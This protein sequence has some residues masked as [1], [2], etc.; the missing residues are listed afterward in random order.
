MQKKSQ[1]PLINM[2]NNHEDDDDAADSVASTD[3]ATTS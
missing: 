1:L 2:V 3:T